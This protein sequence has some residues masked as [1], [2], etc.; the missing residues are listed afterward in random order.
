MPDDYTLDTEWNDVLRSKGI[1]PER[2]K[3]KAFT[4]EDIEQ[5]VENAAKKYSNKVDVEDATLEELEAL[6]DLEDDRVL[7][8]YRKK[9]LGEMQELAKRAKFGNWVDISKPD[10]SSEV[11][12]ASKEHPV[13]VLMFQSGNLLSQLS[14][15]HLGQ[16]AREN[17]VTKFCRIV[18]TQCIE[19]YPESNVPTIIVYVNGAP[20]A[21]LLPNELKRL[22]G[23]EMTIASLRKELDRLGAIGE[24]VVGQAAVQ[25]LRKVQNKNDESESD[26]ESETFGK[27]ASKIKT[28]RSTNHRNDSDSD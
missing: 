4:Q 10:Y 24:S 15:N 16:L 8:F 12:D 21:Q 23:E 2:E 22:G 6:E 1:I 28:I 25:T 9:R 13:V 27:R 17:P 14:M 11:T 5:L 3:E 18:A 26:S 20:V 7:E 19:N